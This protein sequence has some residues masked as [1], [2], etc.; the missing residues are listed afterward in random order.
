[1][2]LIALKCPNC[3]GDIQLDGARK[4]AFCMYC[5]TKIMNESGSSDESRETELVNYLKLAKME[6]RSNNLASAFEAIE[7]AKFVD[8]DISD[9][10]Y[11]MAFL[12]YDNKQ[13]CSQYLR[14]ADE[15]SRSLNVFTMEDA[16]RIL[17]YPVKYTF[18]NKTLLTPDIMAL[19]YFDNGKELFLPIKSTNTINLP[20]GDNHLVLKKMDRSKK[21]ASFKERECTL[22]VNGPCTFQLSLDKKTGEIL[23]EKKDN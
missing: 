23:I 4:F 18:V 5:G 14:R 13:T 17:G 22:T 20:V 19:M 9:I 21:Q 16:D 10:W 3:G 6:I 12:N 11:M 2:P 8:P 15:C 1:M 7:K